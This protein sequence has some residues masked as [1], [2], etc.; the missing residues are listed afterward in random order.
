MP[1]DVAGDVDERARRRLGPVERPV[2]VSE[3]LGVLDDPAA[4]HREV[5]APDDR[6][7]HD[8]QEDALHAVLVPVLGVG[9]HDAGL[10]G[11]VDRE[12]LGEI[13]RRVRHRLQR[14]RPVAILQFRRDDDRLERRIEQRLE[15]GGEGARAL[16]PQPS[17]H[18]VDRFALLMID[19]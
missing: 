7:R 16:P 2:D 5:V 3:R 18:V 12:V 10:V 19:E 14:S 4:I 6:P 17:I 8:V 11:G 1:G 9:E 15:Q 13:D